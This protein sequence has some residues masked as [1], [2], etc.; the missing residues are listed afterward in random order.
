MR[1][2]LPSKNWGRP[3][4]CSGADGP[5]LARQSGQERSRSNHSITHSS[6]NMCEHDSLTGTCMGS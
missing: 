1:L 6:Q 2:V 5:T 3:S 4:S